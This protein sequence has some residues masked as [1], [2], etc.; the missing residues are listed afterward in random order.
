MKFSK[1]TFRAAALFVTSLTAATVAMAQSYTYRWESF[2]GQEWSVKGSSVNSTTGK[3]ETNSNVSDKS[4]AHDGASSLFMAQKAGLTLPELQE[5]AGTLIYWIKALNRTVNVEISKDNST[6]QCIETYKDKSDTWTKHTVAIDDPE[7]RYVRISTTSNTQAYLDYIL[8]TKPDGTDGDGI[9]VV[10]NLYLPYFVNDFENRDAYPED[11]TSASTETAFN[12]EGQGEW[13]YLN[14]YRGSNSQYIS[15]GSS[16][17]LRMLK[18]GSYIIS[19]VVNDGVNKVI[20]N[21]GRTN[22]DLTLYVSTDEG[23][24][25]TAAATIETESHNVITIGEK[26]VN[27]VKLANES[28]SDADV[29]NFAV[30]AFP[31]GTPATVTTG[32]ASDITATTATVTGVISDMGDRK[33]V[34]KGACW[35]VSGD[36]TVSANAVKAPLDE[37]TV[38]LAGLPASSEIRYRAYAVTMAGVAYGEVKSLTTSSPVAPTLS[39]AEVVPDSLRSDEVSIYLCATGKIVSDGGASVSEAG[40]AYSEEPNPTTDGSKEK[41]NVLADGSFTVYIPLKPETKYYFRAYASNSV[42]TSYGDEVSYTTESLMIPEYPHNVYYC[43][44]SGDDATADGSETKPFYSLQKA[45]DIV[46]PGDIIYMNAGTYKYGNRINI[47]T[48]GERGNGMI[49]LESRGGRA[50]L[51]FSSMAVADANQGI[52]MCASYWHVYGLDIVGA[53]DNGM[54]I[55]RNKVSGGSYADIAAKVEQA[56]DN[57]IENCNFIRNADTGLQMKNLAANNKIINC[58][59]YYNTD[60]DNGDADG[61][62]V[63]LSHGDGNYFYGCRAWQNSDDGWDQFIKKEGGFP[64][65]ITTTLEYCWA[66]LNGYLEDGT[67]GKGNGNGFKMG[68]DQGRNNVIMNRCMAFENLNKSFDQNH[69]TGNMILNNCS[70]YATKDTSGKSR[71]S[72]RL[73]EQVATGHEIRLTNCV[74]ISDGISDRNKSAYAP[75]S[76]KGTLISCDMNTLPEDYRSVDVNLALTPRN[77]DGTLPAIDFLRPTEGNSKFIDMGTPVSPYSGESRWAEGIKYNGLAPDLG[78][79]ESDG[80]QG[81]VGAIESSASG[82]RLSLVK[83]HCGLVILQVDGVTPTDELVLGIYGMDGHIV[84]EKAFCGSTTSVNLPEAD[85]VFILNV[86]G[87]TVNESVKISLK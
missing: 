50:V 2:E 29:D 24:T 58:D 59:S 56:H 75:H 49:R 69:N 43:D 44:P 87:K 38:T 41:G 48:I 28:S 9:A 57:I 7:V 14:A 80:C 19:P 25:W 31:A 35:S 47:H 46:A 66:F 17:D 77:E 60:P 74:A 63:K 11:K 39:A 20:F 15:D 78:Y 52:R 22:K 67:K 13:K 26:N 21:E 4:T 34:E 5:G 10:S 30:T 33:L 18:K 54:L 6:W 76:V 65:D 55:E 23:A 81:G 64:D 36:P 83:A 73:D 45:V 72:Y 84:A 12:V 86:K 71:Y 85:G 70:G 61:F 53:G 27:R 79:Y 68:S 62:A 32:A 51:D 42:G 8:V 1:L 37:F 82:R 16:S 40:I 3:W